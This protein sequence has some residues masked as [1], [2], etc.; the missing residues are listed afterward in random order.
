MGLV[1]RRKYSAPHYLPF[2]PSHVFTLRILDANHLTLL[3][4]SSLFASNVINAY[5]LPSPP[6]WSTSSGLFLQNTVFGNLCLHCMAVGWSSIATEE[7]QENGSVS[8][9]FVSA[10]LHFH[11]GSLTFEGYSTFRY[12]DIAAG[13][14]I[15][16]C[17]PGWSNFRK[18][19]FA[20]DKKSV[21]SSFI[22]MNMDTVFVIRME[23]VILYIE[24]IFVDI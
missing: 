2:R 23:D 20:T 9:I 19:V 15:Y 18:S 24:V 5:H 10:F 6:T 11:C 12:H 1:A 21:S 16:G 8:V 4:V 7:L 17:R 22:R 13:R 14:W 3:T